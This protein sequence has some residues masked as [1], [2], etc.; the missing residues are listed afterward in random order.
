MLPEAHLP[1]PLH[2][3][4]KP[5]FGETCVILDAD[6]EEMLW[7]ASRSVCRPHSSSVCKVSFCLLLI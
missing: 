2:G 5:A 6:E 4:A 3:F 7:K 1:F